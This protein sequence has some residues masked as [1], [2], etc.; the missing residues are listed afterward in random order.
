MARD[1]H[2]LE[3]ELQEGRADACLRRGTPAEGRALRF[4]D[5]DAA[6]CS[7]PSRGWFSCKERMND[8]TTL[9]AF[10]ARSMQGKKEGL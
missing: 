5:S 10:S 9:R 8:K 3:L 4:P 1:R 7:L 6:S 2:R